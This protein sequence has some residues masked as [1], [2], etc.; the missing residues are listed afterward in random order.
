MVVEYLCPFYLNHFVLLSVERT[1]CDEGEK[2]CSLYVCIKLENLYRL[3][4][5]QRS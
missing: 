4:C 5:L 1:I 2:E 3:F